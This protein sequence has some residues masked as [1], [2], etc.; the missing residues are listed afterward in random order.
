MPS[1]EVARGA[2]ISDDTSNFADSGDFS[3]SSSPAQVGDLASAAAD[4]QQDEDEFYET[5]SRHDEGSTDGEGG[6]SRLRDLRER[7]PED[8][9]DSEEESS[10]RR[11]AY[12][13]W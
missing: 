8:G 5:G 2:G 6:Q 1:N 13:F 10:A 3:P 9:Y 7:T 11:A 12:G 4:M